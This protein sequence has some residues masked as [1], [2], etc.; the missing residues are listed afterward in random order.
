ML[1]P[2]LRRAWRS[3][4]V[5]GAT[6]FEPAGDFVATADADCTCDFCRGWRAA[7]ALQSNDSKSHIVAPPD[8]DLQRV[9]SAWGS[10]PTHVRTTVLGLL[11]DR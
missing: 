2:A 10:L 1:K 7:L 11:G 5:V 3:Q 9:K 4:R 6:G 8:A